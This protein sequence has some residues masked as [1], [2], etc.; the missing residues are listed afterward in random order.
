MENTFSEDFGKIFLLAFT[1]ELIRHSKNKDITKL[2]RI[3][4]LEESRKKENIPSVFPIEY[5]PA[6]K[7]LEQNISI[8]EKK[9]STK[10]KITLKLSPRLKQFTQ[11][12]TH[13]A[14]IIPEPKL[15][16]HLEYLRPAPAPSVEIDLSKINPLIKDPAVRVIEGNPDEKVVVTGSMGTKPTTII[17]NKEDI[18]R[19]IN[20][21]S[22]VS[23]IPVSE[24]IYRVVVGNLTLSAVISEIVGSRFV[25]KKIIAPRE[26]PSPQ[27][28]PQPM[29]NN[30][31]PVKNNFAQ[32]L[33]H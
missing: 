28:M 9:I 11:Q 15:P 24:G 2:Q 22:E 27:S 4:E 32:L 1:K 21:F 19:I 17:L 33:K 10:P 6:P 23:K 8:P 30:F 3:I 16:S 13:P 29:N 20:K 5:I 18:D 25:I 12:I 26:Q 14:L 7:K 31:M